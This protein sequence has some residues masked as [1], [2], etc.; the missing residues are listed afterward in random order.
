[1]P[2][3]AKPPVRR[4]TPSRFP[5]PDACLGCPLEVHGAGFVPPDGP[6][7]APILLVGEAPGYDEIATGAPMIGAAGS[8]LARVLKLIGTQREDYRIHNVIQCVPPGYEVKRF[9][10]A[11]DACRYLDTTLTEQHPV[12]VP[13]GGTAIRR[14]LQ[15]GPDHTG[16][17]YGVENF[18]G[19]VQRDPTDRF[20]VVPTY[21]PSHLQR[22]AH[23]L[24]G[25]VAHDLLKAHEVAE[26]RYVASPE[27]LILDP[28]LDWFRAWADVY[29]AAATQD[30][31]AYP[32][33]VDIETPEKA[34][35]EGSLATSVNDATYQILR[36]NLSYSPDEG[37]TI[38]WTPE[39]A[40]IL[41]DLLALDAVR[42]FW[43]KGYDEPR[44]IAAYALPASRASRAMNLDLMWAAKALQSDLPQGLGFWA[45]LYVNGPAW[46]HLSDTDPARYAAIDGCR[47]RRVGDGILADLAADGRADVFWR[48]QHQFALTTLQ[49]ATDV[50]MYIDREKLAAFK[51]KLDATATDRLG[52]IQTHVPAGLRP[53]T[54]KG[55]LTRPPVPD[56]LHTKARATK[57]DGSAKKDAPDPLK[58]EV[59]K[60]AQVVE[61]IILAEVTLCQ[62]CG[63][64]EVSK[65]HRCQPSMLEG[66]ADA[67]PIL[68]RAVV[69]VRRWFWQEPFNPDSPLQLLA[70]G[71]HAG[72][73][74]GRDKKSGKPSVD[75]ETLVKWAKASSGTDLGRA[76]QAI[77]DYKAVAKVRGT[78]VLGTEKRL[79]AS[80]RLHSSFLFKPST[81]RL[82]SVAP[83]VQNCIRQGTL[84]E[85]LRDASQY[86][87]G[88]P[89][90]HVRVGD[91]AYSFDDHCRLT[92]KQVTAVHANGEQAVVRVHWYG[93]PR[94]PSAYTDMTP[95]HLVRL[96]DGSWKAAGVLQSGDRILSLA[97]ILS[98][99]YEALLPTGQ[100]T[101]R[102]HR[103]VWMT[104]HPGEPPPPH[105]HHLNQN[106]RDNRLENLQGIEVGDH[107]RWHNTGARNARWR[108][109]YPLDPRERRRMTDRT[110]RARRRAADPE[111]FLKRQREDRRKYPSSYQTKKNSNHRVK[112]V[113]WLPDHVPVY[114]LTIEE[115][116]NYIAGELCVHNCVSDR[117]GKDSLAAGFRDCVIAPVYETAP[118]VWDATTLVEADFAGIEAVILGWCMQDP[119]Y[120]RLAKLGMHA[121]L[122]SHVL[123]RPADLAW[124]DADLAA[125]FADIKQTKDPATKIIYQGSKRT[126]HGNGFG[127]TAMGVFLSNPALFKTQKEAQAIFDLYYTL[128]PSLPAFHQAVRHT[129]YTTH[130][131]GGPPPYHYDPTTHT[132]TGHPYGYAHY[133]WSVVAYERLNEAQRLWRTKRK[134]PLI[135]FNGITWAVTLGEDSKRSVAFLPQS[136]ARGVLTDA[137]FP[138]FD[139]EDPRAATCHI[140]DCWFGQT[141]LRAPIH[142]SLL[143]EVP[144]R[145]AD[146]LIER[147][148]VA[149]QA[150]IPALP[151]PEAWGMGPALTI[152]VDIKVGPSW[153][154]MTSVRV[155]TGVADL[156]ASPEEDEEEDQVDLATRWSA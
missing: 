9:P 38:P 99:G 104:L 114:D 130:K 19:T 22:G 26:G 89:I 69:S 95:D 112:S 123:K 33:A 150:P 13:L 31:Y 7:A 155:P 122:A 116:H 90:E 79:D 8:M 45:P 125:Y 59:F 134:M 97:R 17:K 87:K 102:E 118:G 109:D 100:P 58:A 108:A 53:L 29:I 86:P 101:I 145:S 3:L 32:L 57:R 137:C 70:L 126:V 83:N 67:Q 48:H 55:G 147:V 142:D 30:P 141:P 44:L 60:L 149:M 119:A 105:T 21:H 41:V 65:T 46:K 23:N 93:S 52:I 113:E 148:A 11:V 127:Q 50:G 138:L 2:L 132:V 92:L 140:G 37:V 72:L 152:G 84:I 136:T 151:C 10:G 106:R 6:L 94:R 124:S 128:A 14:I 143:F 153:G 154:D 78:Y 40:A 80:S 85:V 43:F 156:P 61:R 1:M 12:V 144:T 121:Y 91:W 82:S 54:P 74:P 16:K 81:M 63:K 110:S 139:P 15:L 51:A 36:V 34:S 64:Q 35:D 73:P 88:I 56:L 133:F 47:T 24:L 71:A 107:F 77:I 25:V 98:D 131:L 68:V 5:K 96:V 117:D 135:D 66:V 115:T 49:P 75:R 27:S 111:G 18:H 146:R 20:W 28:P 120:V 129:A 76:L 42:Y 4:A 62:T 39:Y 103:F